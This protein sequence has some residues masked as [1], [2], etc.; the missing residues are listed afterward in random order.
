MNYLCICKLYWTHCVRV[1]SK[2]KW[3]IGFSIIRGWNNVRPGMWMDA[4]EG[5]NEG[6]EGRPR[7]TFRT[8]MT[9]F[10]LLIYWNRQHFVT[11]SVLFH[12]QPDSQQHIRLYKTVKP[13]DF[14]PYL[15]SYKAQVWLRTGNILWPLL[16]CFIFN[17]IDN[18]TSDYTKL[19]NQ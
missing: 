5:L 12:F 13:V 1:M 11:T 15:L 16:F 2:L 3:E 10:R 6:V 17:P 7:P 4:T 19:S 14:Q 9:S 18:S 8:L